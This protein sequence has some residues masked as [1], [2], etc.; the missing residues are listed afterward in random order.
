GRELSMQHAT[1]AN[2]AATG[3]SCKSG[4]M[5]GNSAAVSTRRTRAQARFALPARICDA[6]PLAHCHAPAPAPSREDAHE[7]NHEGHERHEGRAAMAKATGPERHRN[8][9][10]TRCTSLRASV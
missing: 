8:E 4:F 6:A 9:P 1:G 3:R 2:A 10:E 7:M 5:R